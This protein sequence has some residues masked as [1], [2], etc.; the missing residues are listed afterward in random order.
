M[1]GKER[2]KNYS[3]ETICSQL[4]LCH[5]GL[6]TKLDTPNPVPLLPGIRLFSTHFKI[7]ILTSLSRMPSYGLIGFNIPQLCAWKL[8]FSLLNTRTTSAGKIISAAP[9]PLHYALPAGGGGSLRPCARDKYGGSA[10]TSQAGALP[11]VRA[12]S[13]SSRQTLHELDADNAG[14]ESP[15]SFY[16][17]EGK[18]RNFFF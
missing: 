5:F 16:F 15:S 6:E 2:V 3:L 4:K 17:D 11:A 18:K 7:N 14:K 9:A 13:L 12:A 10:D 8:G 1:Q